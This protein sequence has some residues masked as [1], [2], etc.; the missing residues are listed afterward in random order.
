M[1][2]KKNGDWG[3]MTKTELLQ[4]KKQ[5]KCNK[6]NRKWKYQQKNVVKRGTN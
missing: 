3:L 2:K 6:E 5:N 4:K 1:K